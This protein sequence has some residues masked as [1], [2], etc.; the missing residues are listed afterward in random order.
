LLSIAN[1]TGDFEELYPK[2]LLPANI[3]VDRLEEESKVPEERETP[4][5]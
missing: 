3:I 5:G 1:A 2:V 4:Q